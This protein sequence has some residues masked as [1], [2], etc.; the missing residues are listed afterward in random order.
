MPQKTNFHPSWWP[1]GH[2]FAD[3]NID[4]RTLRY[5]MKYILKEEYGKHW[6]SLSKKPALG[7][8]WFKEKARANVEAGV[9]PSR[10]VYHP[11]GGFKGREYLM[12]KT[13]RRDYLAEIIAGYAAKGQGI[14]PAR[15]SEYIRNQFD[16]NALSKHIEAFNALPPEEITEIIVS[17]INAKA[18]SARSVQKNLMD[19]DSN[20]EIFLDWNAIRK[21]WADVRTPQSKAQKGRT[22]GTLP[23]GHSDIYAT[24]SAS[25][26][27]GATRPNPS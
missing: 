23:R 9:M 2:V 22:P 7:A 8:E 20:N 1:H 13:T 15:I 16:Q 24:R 25:G 17:E 3:H 27:A 26:R 19:S 12:N 18:P 10:F 6:F 14:D 11:P 4:P 21:G 5:V